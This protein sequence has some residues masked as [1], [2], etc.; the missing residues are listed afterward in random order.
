MTIRWCLSVY[1][2]ACPHRLPLEYFVLFDKVRWLFFCFARVCD[3][4]PCLCFFQN[5]L[6][7]LTKTV[8]GRAIQDQQAGHDSM[9]V[10]FT[11]CAVVLLIEYIQY[12][13]IYMK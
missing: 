8:L 13:Y 6:K 7:V 5:G 11:V 12:I 2:S 4:F 10:R 9:E 3:H 1:L